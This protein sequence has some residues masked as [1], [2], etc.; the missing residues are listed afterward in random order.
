MNETTTNSGAGLLRIIPDN[1][2]ITFRGDLK[3]NKIHHPKP[4]FDEDYKKNIYTKLIM[5]LDI[6]EYVDYPEGSKLGELFDDN[7]LVIVATIKDF[8]E[9]GKVDKDDLLHANKMYKKYKKTYDEKREEEAQ[10]HK[11]I[12]GDMSNV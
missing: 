7:Y 1:T 10:R 3:V 12:L 9:T 2:N 6:I 11:E 8:V 4:E 5:L